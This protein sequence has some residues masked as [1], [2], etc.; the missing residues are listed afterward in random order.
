MWGLLSPSCSSNLQLMSSPCQHQPARAKNVFTSERK[1][2]DGA[3]FHML[4]PW[5]APWELADVLL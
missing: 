1:H 3:R 4:C 5:E 2:Q